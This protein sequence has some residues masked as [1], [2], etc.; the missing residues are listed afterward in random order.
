VAAPDT[1]NIRYV[2]VQTHASAG[3]HR[4]TIYLRAEDVAEYIRTIAA[5][6]ETDAKRRLEEAAQNLEKVR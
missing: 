6:E 1:K 5:S 2:R 4:D 3:R